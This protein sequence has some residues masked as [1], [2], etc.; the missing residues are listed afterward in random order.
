MKDI[1]LLDPVTEL[2]KLYAVWYDTGG[3]DAGWMGIRIDKGGA[4]TYFKTSNSYALNS[5]L[6]LGIACLLTLSL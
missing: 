4:Y 6:I 2:K 3:R 1:P 5:R